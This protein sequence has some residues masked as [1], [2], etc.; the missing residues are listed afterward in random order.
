MSMP[1]ADL[2]QVP[3]PTKRGYGDVDANGPPDI[4][5]WTGGAPTLRRD[6]GRRRSRQ[7]V[8]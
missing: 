6:A 3:G 1:D 5:T 7:Y 2:R 4:E 8:A